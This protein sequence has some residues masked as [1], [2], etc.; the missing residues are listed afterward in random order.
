MLAACAAAAGTIASAARADGDPASDYLLGQQVFF[1]FDA[2]FDAK[3]Q[4]EVA[5]LVKAAN[6]AGFKIRVA[7]IASDY[8]MGSVTSLYRKPRTYARFLAAE[9]SFVYKQRLLVV[10]PNGFGFNWP[11][12][13]AAPAYAVLAKIPIKAGSGGMLDAAGAAVQRLAA[14]AGVKVAA[15]AH[16]TTPA[17]RNSHDR[18]II[19]A[20]VIAALLL[21]VAGRFAL[22]LRSR[23]PSQ[24]R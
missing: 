23:Q 7:L 13:P 22:R 11:K 10:M 3:K 21:A 17:Q 2:K 8:D 20:A 14:A 19:I 18:L 16:V 9:I 15:P 12:H 1:P 6:Q 4:A 5:G 24:R